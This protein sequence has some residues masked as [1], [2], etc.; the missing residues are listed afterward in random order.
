[1]PYGSAPAIV[2]AGAPI[3]SLVATLPQAYSDAWTGDMFAPGAPVLPRILDDEKP[4]VFDYSAGI[5]LYLTPRSG[6]GL[7]PFPTLRTFADLSDALRIVIEAV[8]REIR[9]LEWDIQP[10]NLQDDHDYSDSIV[11][12]RK[13]WKRPDGF[14]EFDSWCNSLLEDLLVIDAVTLWLNID[15]TGV[16]RSVEQIDGATIRPLLDKRGKPP[17]PPIPAYIQNIK[18]MNWQWFTSD[19]LL[20]RPFNTAAT[21]PYG[22]SPTEF[23]IL[24]VNESLR[25][26]QSNTVYWDQTNVPEALVGLPEDMKVEQI[27]AFQEYF[28]AL[29]VGDID[30]LRRLKFLPTKT[31]TIP[32][33][34]FRRPADTSVF[35]EWMI[36]MACWACGILPSE[37]G[38][39]SG[40]RGMGGKGFLEGQENA[41]YRFGLGPMIQYIQ[42][43]ITGIIAMQTDEPVGFK[44]I[45]LGPEEDQQVKSQVRQMQVQS[46]AI[47][48]NV[49]RKEVGQEPIENARPFM[50]VNNVP[51][52]LDDLFRNPPA[53]MQATVASA[54]AQTRSVPTTPVPPGSVASTEPTAVMTGDTARQTDAAVIKLALA[55]WHDKVSRRIRDG[56]SPVCEPTTLSKAVLPQAIVTSIKDKLAALKQE[57][58]LEAFS[59]PLSPEEAQHEHIHD[60]VPLAK[61]APEDLTPTEKTLYEQLQEMLSSWG[62]QIADKIRAGDAIA[63]DDFDSELRRATLP[64]LRDNLMQRMGEIASEFVPVYDPAVASTM[65]SE[66]AKTE[67]FNDIKGITD[68]TRAAVQDSIAAYQSTPGMTRA[69]LEALLQPAFGEARAGSIAVT[70]VTNS[71]MAATTRTQGMLAGFGIDTQEVWH[72]LE[73]KK[74]CIIC[75]ALDGVAANA[76]GEFINRETGIAYKARAAH[77]RCRCTTTLQRKKAA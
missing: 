9:A 30:K 21:S 14:L 3:E 16:L 29:L 72:T 38:I 76:D 26:Q 19:Q 44:F 32:V 25:R 34:E 75:G 58:A 45:N 12:L 5:N 51:I 13:F 56:K 17:S 36:K 23:L 55:D 62:G 70:E 54:S 64:I 77:P 67:L 63:W 71:S 20:Y 74:V 60:G 15:E 65:A 18:G 49:W 27:K 68:V 1:M 47:D 43:L 42:N 61:L 48:I 52:M 66:W 53:A 57:H 2:S 46:G 37:L 22:R 33:H 8:K 39:I 4:R 10:L 11:A 6:Y 31:G 35:D 69:D 28:D 7:L 50:L 24:R 41:Q 73:D 40:G 59:D